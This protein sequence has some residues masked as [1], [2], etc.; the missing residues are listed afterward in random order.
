MPDLNCSEP[1][2]VPNIHT[3][4]EGLTDTQYILLIVAGGVVTAVLILG[5]LHFFYIW[6]YINDEKIRSKLY[7]LALMFPLIVSL[8]ITSMFS[9]RTGPIFSS[10]GVLYLL[11]CLYTITSLCRFIYGSR[12]RLASVLSEEKAILSF[13]VPPCCCCMP[14]LPKAAPS[15]RN[16]KIVECLTLQGP[17]VR[18]FIVILNCH[19]I[20]ERREEADKLLL[21]TELSGILSLLFTIFG[22]HTMAK[23][24]GPYVQQYKCPTMFRFVDISLALFTAQFPLIFDLI[25]VK[26]GVITCGPILS[27]VENAKYIYN[28]VLIC[29]C[30]FCSLL[31]SKLL[32]PEKSALFDKCPHRQL[33]VM[34]T[35]E[36]MLPAGEL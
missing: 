14:C 3:L 7:I 18:A 20:A 19:F 6:K 10:I 15:E 35:R 30:F 36:K 9:P 26:F 24:T 8:A 32:V 22:S 16:L 12:E 11:F 27:A 28:F 1:I 33:Q 29:E 21:I 25:F 23:L 5:I 34:D 17:I 4:Y 2:E 31:A 13:Q